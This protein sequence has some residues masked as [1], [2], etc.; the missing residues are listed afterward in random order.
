M[1]RVA[2]GVPPTRE[3]WWALLLLLGSALLFL[4]TRILGPADSARI[5]LRNID[6][7]TAHLPMTEYG[8]T[9]LAEGRI[10]FWNPFQLCGQPFLA[11]YY[12]GIFYPPNLVYLLLPVPLATELDVIFH[13]MLAGGG[14]WWLARR[15]CVGPLGAAASA[16]TFM[17][18]GW[19]VTMMSQPTGIGAESWM[20][21]TLV[22]VDR[23][24]Q[25]AYRAW[26]WLT[27]GVGTQVMIGSAEILSHVMYVAAAFALLRLFE[28]GRSA[29]WQRAWRRG[30]A[31]A[32]SVAAGTALGSVQLLPTFELA[33]ESARAPE[34]L[35]FLQSLKAGHFPP[36]EFL[37]RSLEFDRWLTVGALPL[38]LGAVGLGD[39]PRR[40][41]WSLGLLCAGLGAL[42]VFG[43]S[44]YRFYFETPIG[45]LFRGPRKF[46]D[47]YAFG[48]SLL[49]GVALTRLDTWREQASAALWRHPAWLAGLAVGGALLVW[50]AREAT[51]NLYVLLGL[52]LLLAF[53]GLRAPRPRSVALI[54]LVTVQVASLLAAEPN[55]RM[56]PVQLRPDYLAPSPALERLGAGPGGPRSYLSPALSTTTGF[57]P[58][59]GMLASVPVV[60]D[61]EPLS[62]GRYAEYFRVASGHRKPGT[63]FHGRYE[64]GPRT[65]WRLMDLTGTRYY[66]VKA[67]ESIAEQMESDPRF[68]LRATAGRGEHVR[69]YE[70]SDVMPRAWFVPDAVRLPDRAAVMRGLRL[71]FF[72]PRRTVL[73]EGGTEEALALPGEAA[74]QGSV[75]IRSYRPEHVEL[76]VEATGPGWVVLS[77]LYYPGWTASVDGTP[78]EPQRAN[79]LF[80]AV[81][82]G[83]GRSIVRFSYRPGSFRLGLA[84]SLGA[85]V[86]TLLVAFATTRR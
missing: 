61:Y 33:L 6:L 65:A 64:L 71:P 67:T 84:A 86:A 62:L 31:L 24:V 28:L 44:F 43:G 51:W 22:L 48:Q 42:L 77:D 58:K 25:G 35:S 17:W 40:T 4:E 30:A 18:S 54:A 46:L 9:A 82:V 81:E 37:T 56:R 23:A 39:R 55:R 10:P 32:G 11:A 16:L 29:G 5:D 73:L 7:F 83:E 66:V 12:A 3:L 70:R 60:V 78:V 63:L 21:L 36:A 26:L 69:I 53:G 80:R 50:M 2:R 52:G 72:D 75:Q 85:A 47:V 15:L 20:P 14:M 57:W 74:S 27:L 45:G 76:E 49:L 68:A 41:A 19:M 79:Y 13:S 8:F 34:T 38:V 59:H 1:P